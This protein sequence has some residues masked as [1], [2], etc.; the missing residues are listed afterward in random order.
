[1][2]LAIL[3]P[4][5]QELFFQLFTIY[6]RYLI[7]GA[8]VIAA[9][10][11]GKIFND[12]SIKLPENPPLHSID[13]FFETLFYS[14]LYYKFIGWSQLISGF[15]LMTQKFARV[16]II[17]FFPII[18]N[19]FVI[20][21]SYDF[22][23]TEFITGLILLAAVYLLLWDYEALKYI[24]FNPKANDDVSIDHYT[25]NF[26]WAIIGLILFTSIVGLSIFKKGA[27][28]ILLVCFIE[29]FLSF[30]ILPFITFD[31]NKN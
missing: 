3:K 23:G 7:G 13:R 22:Q 29:G 17:L 20:T 5:R 25:T 2:T 10:G 1:M 12:P 18:L 15:L 9:F 31:K 11:M 27:G 19:I 28:L 21:I 26:F 16:G 30:I 6:T 8:F 4:L 14:G 24:V